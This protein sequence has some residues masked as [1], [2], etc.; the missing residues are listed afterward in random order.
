MMRRFGDRPDRLLERGEAS[1][2]A[3]R[4][5]WTLA[6]VGLAALALL[7]LRSNTDAPSGSEVAERVDAPGCHSRFS[8]RCL[9]EIRYAYPAADLSVVPQDIYF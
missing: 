5:S 4:T 9:I 1:M 7:G 6:L 8:T 2:T 3:F